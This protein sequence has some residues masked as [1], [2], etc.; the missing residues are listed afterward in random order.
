LIPAGGETRL[1]P[2]SFHIM[3]IGLKTPLKL[4]E[5]IRFKLTFEDG[6]SKNV[7]APVRKI[8]MTMPMSHDHMK[9]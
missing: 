6:S 8:D 2:G 7:V 3:L 1:K 9:H 5:K 4:D